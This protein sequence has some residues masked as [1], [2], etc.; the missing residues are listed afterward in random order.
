MVSSHIERLL[1]GFL[2]YSVQLLFSS[3]VDRCWQAEG[4]LCT[5]ATTTL[6]VKV[7]CVMCAL[8]HLCSNMCICA[9]FP[10]DGCPYQSVCSIAV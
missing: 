10:L 3:G 6:V 9:V 2:C 8:P 5:N 7:L 1:L 4:C